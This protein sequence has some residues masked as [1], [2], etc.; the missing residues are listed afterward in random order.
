MIKEIEKLFIYWE[1]C[2]IIVGTDLIIFNKPLPS[3][4][5]IIP[6]IAI[7]PFLTIDEKR[8]L[9][10]DVFIELETS[11]SEKINSFIIWIGLI[12]E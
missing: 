9:R 2:N 12:N 8:F 11:D 10:Y 1:G 5:A 4:P 3:G 6:A 7:S